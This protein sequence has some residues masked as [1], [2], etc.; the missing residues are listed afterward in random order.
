MSRWYREKKREHYYKEAK[1][2]GY[3][4]RSAYKLIQIQKRF[5]LIEHDDVV[6][7]LGAAPGGWSQVAVN[8]VGKQ[9]RVIGVDILPIQPLEGAEFL[10]G[11]LTEQ[12]TL[13]QLSVL[14][15]KQ[16][17]D[18]VL[19][20]MSPD[21]T[22]HYSIDQAR[23]RWLCEQALKACNYL[24]KPGGHLVCK[25]FEGEDSNEFLIQ[26]KHRFSAVKTFT[27]KASRK[28]SSEIYIIAKVLKR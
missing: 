19:S 17:A 15:K 6:I 14:M 28:S 9:G 12:S 5:C 13:D 11:D 18:V 1:R 25:L 4:A 20:D 23:S 27:P 10:Q 7:D 26:V 24:L 3:R 16:K 21:I 2:A 22:G 8:L